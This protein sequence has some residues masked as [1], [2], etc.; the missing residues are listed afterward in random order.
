M[1]QQYCTPNEKYLKTALFNICFF[2]LFNQSG[3]FQLKTIYVA[4]A[5]SCKRSAKLN[6]LLPACLLACLCI[7]TACAHFNV[8]FLCRCLVPRCLDFSIIYADFML[9]VAG[10]TMPTRNQPPA[11]PLSWAVTQFRATQHVAS[12][13]QS[14]QCPN[15]SS[16]SATNAFALKDLWLWLWLR[17]WFLLHLQ[18]VLP[19]LGLLVHLPRHHPLLICCN[20]KLVHIEISWEIKFSVCGASVRFL[21]FGFL[22]P[23]F[24]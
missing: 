7:A 16:S 18:L 17:L 24:V 9:R 20:S 4:S 3:S 15:E 5:T 8:F 12:G 13:S 21:F 23:L 6:K 11:H 1:A 14:E 22:R 19:S 10:L 2:I